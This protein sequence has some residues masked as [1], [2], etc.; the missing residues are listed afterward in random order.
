QIRLCRCRGAGGEFRLSGR[1]T[2][3]FLGATR[4][5]G[6]FLL[7]GTLGPAQNRAVGSQSERQATPDRDVR[8]CSRCHREPRLA[9]QRW[10]RPCRTFAQRDRRARLR[11]KDLEQGSAVV[12]ASEVVA[13]PSEVDGGPDVGSSSVAPAASPEGDRSTPVLPE[14]L[15]EALA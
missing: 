7:V 3:A 6:L 4:C 5:P 12:N 2:G 9:G 13:R 11:A 15:R 14:A 10:C 8:P 1:F